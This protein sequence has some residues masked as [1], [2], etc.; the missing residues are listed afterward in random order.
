MYLICVTYLFDLGVLLFT[1]YLNYSNLQIE[2]SKSNQNQQ[3]SNI[4][5]LY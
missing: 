4:L 5:L 2:D 1:L 3:K